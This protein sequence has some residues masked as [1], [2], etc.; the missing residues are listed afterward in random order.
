MG[1]AGEKNE[2]KVEYNYDS[3]IK[4]QQL[5]SYPRLKLYTCHR[6]ANASL[7]HVFKLQPVVKQGK[8]DLIEYKIHLS[9]PKCI[10]SERSV[11]AVHYGSKSMA[12]KGDAFIKSF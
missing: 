6:C 12:R 3:W 9:F 8:I 2:G 7:E 4:L 10:L 1:I 5:I 11:I